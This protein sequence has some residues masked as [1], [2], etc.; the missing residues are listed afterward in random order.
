MQTRF[1]R[2]VELKKRT[3][4]DRFE[5]FGGQSAIEDSDHSVPIIYQM[6]DMA[7]EWWHI[8]FVRDM[9]LEKPREEWKFDRKE[10]LN[11]LAYAKVRAGIEEKRQEESK[12]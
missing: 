11:W 12:V 3:F 8:P 6:Y 9:L 10:M 4:A 5:R 7:A 2:L 1:R